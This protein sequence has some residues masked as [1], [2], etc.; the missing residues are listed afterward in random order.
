M[1]IMRRCSRPAPTPSATMVALSRSGANRRHHPAACHLV[2]PLRPI[3]PRKRSRATIPTSFEFDQ[4]GFGQLPSKRATPTQP[5]VDQHRPE[6]MHERSRTQDARSA[7]PAAARNRARANSPARSTSSGHNRPSTYRPQPPHPT[8]SNPPPP[9][10]GGVFEAPSHAPL[11][12]LLYQDESESAP[13]SQMPAMA[14]RQRDEEGGY[15][16]QR[17][18]TRRSAH[19]HEQPHQDRSQLRR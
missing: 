3:R 18:H 11:P 8:T 13:S 6:G 1:I 9:P 16:R 12:P 2:R 19:I 7:S 14:R 5:F 4:G 10:P 17:P 15:G